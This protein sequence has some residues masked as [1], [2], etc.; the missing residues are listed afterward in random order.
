MD[1]VIEYIAETIS[2]IEALTARQRA[3]LLEVVQRKLAHQPTIETR[4]RKRLR[5]NPLSAW[6]LR[7]GELRVYYDVNESPRIVTIRAVG[8]KDRNRVSIGKRQG[9][10][11]DL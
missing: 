1:Y 3:I 5:P 4:N 11:E 7:I 6:E 8:I 2:H 9:S 10:D